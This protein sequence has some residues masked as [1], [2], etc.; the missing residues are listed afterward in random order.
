MKMLLGAALALSVVLAPVAH[1]GSLRQTLQDFGF[2]GSWAKDCGRPADRENVWREITLTEDGARF[3]ESLGAGFVPSSYRV[4]AAARRGPDT[5]VLSIELN[6]KI[7][8]DLTMVRHGD[9]IRT[10]VNQP[11]GSSD[12]VVQDGVVT[13]NGLSTPWLTR[14][15]LSRL[16][17]SL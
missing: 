4:L 10:M 17:A 14:C 13:A 12:P 5:I 3:T 2:V 15:E 11:A 16:R 8:Q 6:G 1:A 9:R 7:E